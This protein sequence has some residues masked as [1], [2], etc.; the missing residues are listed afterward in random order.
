[1]TR[2]VHVKY[3]GQVLE[4][5]YEVSELQIFPGLWSWKKRLGSERVCPYPDAHFV[6]PKVPESG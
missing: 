6:T 3:G 1:M 5:D 2:T 4:I